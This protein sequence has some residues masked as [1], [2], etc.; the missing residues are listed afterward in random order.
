MGWQLASAKNNR[1]RKARRK[2]KRLNFP[3]KLVMF[4]LTNLTLQMRLISAPSLAQI[5]TSA[6]LE[7]A[8]KGTRERKR[9]EALRNIKLKEERLRKN[10]PPMPYKI[11][12]MLKSK[13]LWGPPKPVREKDTDLQ[14]PV[15]NV[16]FN[17][18]FAYK[19]HTLEEAIFN[20]KQVCHPSVMNE[21]NAIVHAKIEFDMRATKKDR[22]LD[23]FS[24]TVPILKAYDRN[25]PD[26]QV[27]VF[28]PNE[29][30][31]LMALQEG[32]L[33]AGG[34]DLIMEISKGQVDIA[35]VDYFLCHEELS[36]Q[37][38]P[39]TNSIREKAPSLK[40]GTI[41]S[42]IKRM[43]QTFSKGMSLEVKK[44]AAQI[45]VAEEPDYASCITTIGRLGKKFLR[46]DFFP[47]PILF[48]ASLFFRNVL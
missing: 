32:A 31:R 10:P 33:M 3:K 30:L 26:R 46:I 16:Y 22:Y 41:G 17:H 36:G 40:N 21:P 39:L 8:R 24:K 9:K 34:H 7:R 48:N 23:G 25:V 44:V 2:A 18:D 37:V 12:L 5:H 19:R 43:I 42:D 14:F 4:S 27:V 11:E 13:G 1:F 29:D 35:E 45:G 28:V 20:L 15:D 47:K 6:I 38:R